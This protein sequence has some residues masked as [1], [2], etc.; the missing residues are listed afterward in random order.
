MPFLRRYPG[1]IPRLA[2]HEPVVQRIN[3][4][5]FVI[6]KIHIFYNPF[7][8]SG[9]LF[10]NSKPFYKFGINIFSHFLQPFQSFQRIPYI[11]P[12]HQ[13]GI[14]IVI[15]N[16][17]VF[18]RSRH[19]TDTIFVPLRFRKT[20]NIRPNPGRLAQYFRRT[21]FKKSF[22]PRYISIKGKRISNIRI[23]VV[24]GCSQRKIRRSL[25]AVN[26]PPREQCPFRMA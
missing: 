10:R 26:R 2:H 9:F 4:S 20:P 18:I 17:I 22:I 23:D 11:F 5:F 21:L 15:H 3:F 6:G 13:V 16:G 19:R 14:K 7:P 8:V 12:R 25:F 24:L 1:I